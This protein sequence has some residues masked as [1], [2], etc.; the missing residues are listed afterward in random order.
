MHTAHTYYSL[1]YGTLSPEALAEK[2]AGLGIEMLVL[3]DINNTTACF[4]F[5]KACG[6][7]NIKPIIGMQARNGDRLLYTCIS[8]NHEGLREIN[9]FL[10][11][12]NLAGKKLPDQAPAFEHV[13]VLYPPLAKA[14]ETLE[15]NEFLGIRPA[16]VHRTVYTLCR[17][18]PH[19]LVAQASSCYARRDEYDLHC[20]LRAIDHNVVLSRL[21]PGQTAMPDE[22]F[23]PSG[24]IGDTFGG[25]G[26]LVTNAERLLDQCEIDF[27]F[28]AP[29]NKKT[30]TGHPADDRALLSK[31]A[32]D[33]LAYRY[34]HN[35]KEATRRVMH[36]LDIIDKL[37]FSS[38]FLI[39]WD[40]IRYSMS[41]GFYHVGRG[42]GA[43][44]IVAYCLRITNVDPIELDL[45]FERFINPKRSTPPDFDIDYSWRDRDQVLDYIF[46][47]Y[48]HRHTA[49]LG[50]SI[51]FRDRSMIRELGKVLEI[52][53]LPELAGDAPAT[54]H[55][56]STNVLINAYKAM[57]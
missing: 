23:K 18:Y 36:E 44:S 49:L 28:K 27:D 4:D 26:Q 51:T 12:H 15:E 40:I 1:L 21:G 6:Q 31:L 34:G 33:G 14:P 56:A 19:K 11:V 55:D 24:I 22:T 41:C 54:R 37:G 2:A 43:N 45:Y 38:Y 42:S 7:Y 10:S 35:N 47:R 39:T 16:D 20:H 5:V 46:K 52:A 32:M 30:F 13:Y 3:T 48:G 29:K 9:E 50:T 8:R 17:E 57:R 25:F 53:I